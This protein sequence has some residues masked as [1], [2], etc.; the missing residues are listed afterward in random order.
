[1]TLSNTSSFL[2][3]SVQLIFSILLQHHISELSRCFWSTARRVQFYVKKCGRPRQV[4]DD[5]IMLHRK[6]AICFPNNVGKDIDTHSYSLILIS[7]FAAK[8]VTRTRFTLT[9]FCVLYDQKLTGLN[10]KPRICV[11]W[12][13]IMP[14]M[15][16]IP[17]W[18][19]AVVTCYPVWSFLLFFSALSNQT[20]G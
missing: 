1:L 18:N 8:I 15:L 5:N 13:T 11:Y 17:V 3:W 2:T 16:W 4:A 9:L 6:D 10:F 7:F 19:P 14:P 20:S 12:T